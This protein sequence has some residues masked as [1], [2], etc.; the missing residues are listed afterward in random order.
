[1][2]A[3][4]NK[5]MKDPEQF[6]VFEFEKGISKIKQMTR[7]IIGAI[8]SG[9]LQPGY[10]LPSM[11]KM[12]R[13]VG[14]SHRSIAKVIRQL[15]SAGYV[16]SYPR[17]AT[18]VRHI[19]AGKMLKGLTGKAP[20]PINMFH[21]LDVAP[22]LPVRLKTV[23]F[24]LDIPYPD[25]VLEAKKR[26]KCRSVN[27]NT[28]PGSY[29][30]QEAKLVARIAGNLA[31]F[32]GVSLKPSQC[33]VVRGA[34]TVFT[35]LF[36]TLYTGKRKK[37]LL[38]RTIAPSVYQACLNS[39]FE[40]CRLENTDNTTFTGRLLERND[41]TEVAAVVAEPRFDYY[42]GAE[43]SPQ[44]RIALL[45][46]AS[47][48][49]F[50][51][52]EVDYDHEFLQGRP[53]PLFAL[54]QE[55]CILVSCA[56]KMDYALYDLKFVC[57]PLDLVSSLRN[58]AYSSSM[59]EDRYLRS[60]TSIL[61]D[62]SVSELAFNK[63]NEAKFCGEELMQHFG[64]RFMQEVKIVYRGFGTS[65]FCYFPQDTDMV[66]MK[67]LLKEQDIIIGS[68]TEFLESGRAVKL[69]RLGLLCVNRKAPLKRIA[70]RLCAAYEACRVE[71]PRF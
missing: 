62:L 66:R 34:N 16:V 30:A 54:D 53:S 42:T 41:L 56:S 58:F 31:R 33:V 61:K 45:N 60:V 36:G 38:P 1:M 47:E 14:L 65:M 27:S 68:A 49:G 26:V 28:F 17:M 23:R 48:N 57:G 6:L 71:A 4:Q 52:I 7:A 2:N 18:Y 15:E 12:Q 55:N 21:P 46:L 10:K 9:V 50:P 29:G 39:P 67:Y 64:K 5:K 59:N 43:M 32:S 69:L 3:Y 70:E 40:T 37:L 22:A 51:V 35:A 11:R 13:S 20:Y 25:P 19:T 63:A 8:E 24:D 44:D